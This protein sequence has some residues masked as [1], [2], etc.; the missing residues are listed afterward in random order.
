MV[1][2]FRITEH[3]YKPVENLDKRLGFENWLTPTSVLIE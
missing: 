2:I 3:V 1:Y